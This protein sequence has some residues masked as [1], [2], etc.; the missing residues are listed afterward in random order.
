M[1]PQE[2]VINVHRDEDWFQITAFYL[3]G[4][5]AEYHQKVLRLPMNRAVDLYDML[6]R[7]VVK[8]EKEQEAAKP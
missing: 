7:L 4:G 6:H 1:T 8:Y 5:A 2:I 3:P